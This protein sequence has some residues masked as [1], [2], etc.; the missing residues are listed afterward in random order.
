VL[1]PVAPV[2]VVTRS[3]FQDAQGGG[4]AIGEFE[5]Q[6]KGAQEIAQL[7]RW[8]EKK[9]EKLVNEPTQQKNIA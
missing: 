6:G 3:A 5:P 2:P 8:I 9:M 7:W 4:L 1:G